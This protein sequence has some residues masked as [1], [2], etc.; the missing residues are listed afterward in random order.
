MSATRDPASASGTFLVGIAAE[1]TG[2]VRFG[3]GLACDR[4]RGSCRSGRTSR[5]DSRCSYIERARINRDVDL[6]QALVLE[7]TFF[8]VMANFTVDAIHAWLDPRMRTSDA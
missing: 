5:G 1:C 6:V 2:R 3:G 8:I 4:C 7:A